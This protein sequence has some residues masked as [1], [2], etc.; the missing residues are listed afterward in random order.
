MGTAFRNSSHSEVEQYNAMDEREF[1]TEI[2]KCIPAVWGCI[3]AVWGLSERDQRRVVAKVVRGVQRL[4]RLGELKALRAGAPLL[5]RLQRMAHR[6]AAGMK[7]MAYEAAA[8]RVAR[9]WHISARGG[10]R[11]FGPPRQARNEKPTNWTSNRLKTSENG[12]SAPCSMNCWS[13]GQSV[14]KRH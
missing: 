3:A 12:S 8:C 5:S 2:G 4:H 11:R 14:G 9:W 1:H 6:A 7:M 10:E 13:S